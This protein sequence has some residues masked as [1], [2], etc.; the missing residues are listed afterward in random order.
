MIEGVKTGGTLV[1]AVVASFAEAAKGSKDSAPPVA[2][3]WTDADGQWLPLLPALRSAMPNLFTLGRYNPA[4]RTGPSIW[5]KCIVDRV[6]PEAGPEDSVPVLYLPRVNRQELRA[7]GECPELLKPLVELQYRGRV[8]HQANGHD[9]TVRAMLCSESGLG[10]DVAEDRRTGE[11]F[12]R[13]LPVLGET[14]ARTL[15]GRRLDSDDFNKL[16]VPDPVRDLLLWLNDPRG[17][18]ALARGAG[19]RGA[20]GRWESFA[21]LCQSEF[22]FSPENHPAAEVA[23]RLMAGDAALERVWVRFL[24]APQVYEG[25]ARLMSEPVAG[26][27]GADREFEEERDPLV[28]ERL[29]TE[30]R[31]ELEAAALLPQGLACE[32]VLALEAKHGPRRKWVW[33]HMD[34]SVW[35]QALHPLARLARA[36]QV[37]VGGNTLQSVAEAYATRGWE[38]D[39]AAME[40]LACGRKAVEVEILGR[41]VRTMYEPWLAA[42]A[43]HFQEVVTR[44]GP[45]ARKAVGQAGGERDTCM[46][47]VDGLRFDVAAGL[48]AKLEARSLRVA[49]RHRMSALPT[50]TATAKPAAAPLSAETVAGIKAGSGVDFTPLIEGK[51]GWKPLTAPLLREALESAGVEVWDRDEIRVPAGTEGGGWTESGSI[52]SLGHALEGRL[53]GQLQGEVNRVAERVGALLDAGWQRVRVVTDHGW[54]LLPGGLPKVDLPAYLTETKWARCALVKGDPQLDVPVSE[55]HWGPEVKIAS[56][57]GIACFRTGATYAHGGLS[58]QECVVPELVV[59]RGTV[60]A[61]AVI[62]SVEWRG[63]RCRVRVET[64]DPR[65]KVDV[66][67]HW[68]QAGTSIVA[69]KEAGSSGEVSLVVGDDSNEGVAASVVI[70]DADGNVLAVQT[71]CVGERA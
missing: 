23:G 55:W 16:T 4:E 22:G 63:M 68:K 67:K 35:A 11:A 10:L 43:R 56:P 6:L 50:V 70:S 39:A 60:G 31:G 8:W 48:A 21:G 7:P 65:V 18:D 5:L 53:A 20:G 58:P 34:R 15:R 33:A 27:G 30:L 40:G 9:W 42:S 2:V 32:R 26:R 24:E 51:S 71:T 25:V 62:Q 12:L 59:E 13:A 36:A 17:F 57:P 19:A 41:I 1:E 38:A 45:Q 54:L 14:D 66:R 64:N 3:V 44:E 29:E 28:N 52:D 49:V 37:P 69:E 47:F 61:R 46:V